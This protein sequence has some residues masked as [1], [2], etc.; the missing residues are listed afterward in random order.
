MIGAGPAG[1]ASAAELR[2]RGR[3]GGGARARRRH[4]DLVARAL[5]PPAP[6]LEPLVLEAPGR[7]ATRRGTG[8]FPLARRGRRLPR[9][10][11]ARQRP[12]RAPATR[13]WTASTPTA[14]AGSCAP[15]TATSRP[16]R[17]SSRP[18]TS[19]RRTCPS[20]PAASASRRAAARGRVPQ[21][22]S[23]PRPRRARG[24]PGLLG[25]GDRLRPRRGRGAAGQARGAHAA[26]HARPLAD[27]ARHRAGAHARCARS[28][29]T[30]IANFVRTQGDRRPDRV[31]PARARGGHVQPP[32]PPG[33]RAGDRRQG[34]RSR[35]S[36]SGA[37]RSS[38]ASSRSTRPAS[39]WPTA[40]ASS[41][42]AVIAATGYRRGL[43]PMVGH[44]DVLDDE[45]VPRAF[46]AEAG[47]ARPALRRLPA[48]PRAVALLGDRGQ[49]GGEGDRPRA[50][51]AARPGDEPD[52]RLRHELG[53]RS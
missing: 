10:L 42:D 21:P 46:A 37:S 34:R 5:R 53:R 38:P 52:G 16:S 20:G 11:R 24:R 9:G 6:E 19:T 41:R 39:G 12:R 40:R 32:A 29:P 4:R 15:R 1:L 33:R 22:R 14:R 13:T 44:L 17:W 36:A 47:R 45:G 27:R 31:R 25:H 49:A 48:H 3:A 7:R 35:R 2:R 50:A 8:I 30:A 18:A 23:L 26:E 43:E 51:R 28:A